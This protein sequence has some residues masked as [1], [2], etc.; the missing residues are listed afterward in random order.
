MYNNDSKQV[1]YG[2]G[3]RSRKGL[4]LLTAVTGVST[5]FALVIF[6]V[7][8]SCITSVD[9]IGRQMDVIGRLSV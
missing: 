3:V 1:E 2:P 9:S 7:K 8:A 4:L 5:A 6:R